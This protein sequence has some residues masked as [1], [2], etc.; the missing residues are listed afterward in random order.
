MVGARYS[1]PVQ[2]APGP[3]QRPVQ[4]ALDLFLGVK[5]QGHGVGHP[6]PSSTK[7]K[8]SVELITYTLSGPSRPV[9]E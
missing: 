4:W 1:A 3:T 6:S 7:A 8:E 9:L 2:L 5:Q